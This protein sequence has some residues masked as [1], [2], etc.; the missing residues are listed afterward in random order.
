MKAIAHILIIVILTL[1]LIPCNETVCA[2]HNE[3]SSIEKT[4]S[5]S[6]SDS[7]SDADH[8]SPFCACA[9][10]HTAK[11]FTKEIIHLDIKETKAIIPT[12]EYKF[13]E[14]SFP[15]ERYRPPIV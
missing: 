5:N 13:L 15:S 8:C 6:H 1:N 14:D 9:C 2:N 4:V 11:N 10:S 7:H 12:D 3:K